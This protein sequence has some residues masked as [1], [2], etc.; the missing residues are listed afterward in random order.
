MVLNPLDDR[1]Q[2]TIKLHKAEQTV[3]EQQASE[4]KLLHEFNILQEQYSLMKQMFAKNG[5][6]PI[7]SE[8][9]EKQVHDALSKSKTLTG[10]GQLRRENERLKSELE[11]L[12]AQQMP[13]STK[14]K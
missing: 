1:N 3:R 14:C 11:K 4:T 7:I 13:K 12:K 9:L 10:Q 2:L 6:P 5:Q 8:Q